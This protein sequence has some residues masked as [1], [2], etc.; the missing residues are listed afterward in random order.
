MTMT[1]ETLKKIETLIAIYN[2]N[3]IGSDTDVAWMI[4]ANTGMLD[5]AVKA[6]MTLFHILN[7]MENTGYV[8]D[9]TTT[10]DGFIASIHWV[11]K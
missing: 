1:N 8:V 6:K 11:K 10:C 7:D 3:H 2:Q 9:M 5:R 4:Q